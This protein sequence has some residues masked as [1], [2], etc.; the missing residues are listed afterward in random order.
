MSYCFYGYL[1][2]KFD[3]YAYLQEI[4]SITFFFQVDPLVIY[5]EPLEKPHWLTD[6]LNLSVQYGEDDYDNMGDDDYDD[7][8]KELNQYKKSKD[9]GRG[10]FRFQVAVQ[11]GLIW[12]EINDLTGCVGPKDSF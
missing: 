10:E 12:S 2:I 3:I 9:R 5:C 8:S 7:Y 11:R 4:C 6:I 1:V